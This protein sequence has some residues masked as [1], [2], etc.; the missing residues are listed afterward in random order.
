MAIRD[1]IYLLIEDYWKNV[2]D[3]KLSSLA[4]LT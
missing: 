4:P 2:Q 3:G 1:L